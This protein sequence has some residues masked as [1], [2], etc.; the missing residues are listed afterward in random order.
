[1]PC[2]VCSVC[3]DTIGR[4]WRRCL[5]QPDATGKLVA[6][7]GLWHTIDRERAHMDLLKQLAIVTVV[8]CISLALGLM[9]ASTPQ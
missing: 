3:A 4:F 2:A 1:M 7:L 9:L 5:R 6:F 8:A